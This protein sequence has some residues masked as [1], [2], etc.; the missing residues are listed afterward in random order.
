MTF[1]SHVIYTVFS[2]D[3]INAAIKYNLDTSVLYAF[4][5][6]YSGCILTFLSWLTIA[7][8]RFANGLR[9]GFPSV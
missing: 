7:A 8:E 2:T 9:R 3:P 4:K 5:Y 6:L 1:G